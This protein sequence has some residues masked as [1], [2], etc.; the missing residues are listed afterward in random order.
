[1]SAILGSLGLGAEG[2][3]TLR[4]M[5]AAQT[6]ESVHATSADGRRTLLLDAELRDRSEL[7]AALGAAGIDVPVAPAAQDGPADPAADAALVLAAYEA[8]GSEALDRLDG[9]FA[10][11]LHDA[12][13]GTWT[14][15]R[16]PFGLRP[17]HYWVEEHPAGE[18]A[19][20]LLASEVRTLLASGRVERSLDE[21]AVHRFLLDGVLDDGPRTLVAGVRRVQPGELVTLSA[22][23]VR[24]DRFSH[25]RE[26]LEAIASRPGRPLGQGTAAEVRRLLADAV[27]R[28]L[29]GDGPVSTTATG[30]LASAALAGTLASASAATSGSGESDRPQPRAALLPGTDPGAAEHLDAL[31]AATAG[32][33]ETRLVALDPQRFLAELQDLVL[34]LDEPVAGPEAYARWAV[35]RGAAP[36]GVEL[37]ALGGDEATGGLPEHLAVHLRA[38]RSGR[39]LGT[40]ARSAVGA[41]TALREAASETLAARTPVP[42]AALLDSG[43]VAAHERVRP[44]AAAQDLSARLVGDVFGDAL[45][46]RLRI[47]DRLSRAAGIESR[48]PFLDRRLL[49]LLLSLE[50][51]AHMDGGRPQRI[52]RE[53]AAGLLPAA[54]LGRSG[55]G[56]TVPAG[57]WLVALAPAVR[58]IFASDA[59]DARPFTDSRSVLALFDDAVAHPEHHRTEVLW[60]LLCLELWLRAV[61]DDP[62]AAPVAQTPVEQEDERPKSDYDANPGKQLDLVSEADGITWRRFPLQTALV[63]RGDDVEAIARERV[64]TFAAGLQDGALPAGAPWYFV[65]SEKIIAITQGRSWFTWEIHPRPAA[66]I[67]SRF[68]TRTPAGIGLGDPTT[69]E[70]ALRE[71]GLPRV[72]L[73]SAAGAAGKL[74]GRRGVFYEVVGANVRAIDGPTPY[75]AFPSNVSAKLP[76]KDPDQ[77]SARISAAIRASDLPAAVRD[78]FVGTVV[79][80]ANDIGRNV[81]GTDVDTPRER[82]EATF[83]DNPLG[84]GR[85][86]TP[87]AILVDLGTTDPR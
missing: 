75:S 11:A 54:A 86:R 71:V 53:A 24:T 29:P 2:E 37:S 35:L 83:A 50:D 9:G 22:D 19:A 87:L 25:L 7:R 64:E 31:A 12:E 49:T 45:R 69:M 5:R 70:L 55:G 81:L 4:R 38:L 14:L 73:A 52:L 23:G 62:D 47:E 51:S 66:K 15:A 34:L 76:P 3:E 13:A 26:E 57:A 18:G 1:M 74:L 43:F 58:E 30:D 20:A 79:M 82:L 61:L 56:A 48:A 36:G 46:T 32:R 78:A 17:L 42:A 8:W 44:S 16:D 65:I 28:A 39:R 59:F 72:V 10:L 40:L 27:H 63:A 84:Q 6:G 80:D 21:A 41:R 67:L 60:R 68:V 33:L 85:Q 77:V